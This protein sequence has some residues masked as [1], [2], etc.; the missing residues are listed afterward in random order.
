M[1]GWR[2][3]RLGGGLLLLLALVAVAQATAMSNAVPASG[4]IMSLSA[5]TAAALAPPEC[6]GLT[7]STLV[8]VPPGGSLTINTPNVLVLGTDQGF[9]L[10]T[11][12]GST[13][14][15]GGGGNDDLYA[16]NTSGTV[17]L[18]GG[19]GADELFGGKGRNLL[20]GGPGN[21]RLTAGGGADELYGDDGDDTLKGG[22]GKDLCVGGPG[23]DTISKCET[24]IQ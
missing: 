15:V 21:D 1:P 22:G 19:A 16:D 24:V 7:L 18:M 14:V 9:T 12:V 11:K 8:V 2:I 10:R 17:V 3:R 4:A 6:D 23:N 20:Y 13:C 5:I